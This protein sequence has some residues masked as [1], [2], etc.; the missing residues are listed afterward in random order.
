[1]AEAVRLDDSG[2]RSAADF[3]TR[4]A[5]LR[6]KLRALVQDGGETAQ[7]GGEDALAQL[8]DGIAKLAAELAHRRSEARAV[9][10]RLADFGDM[11]AALVG[12]NYAYRLAISDDGNLFD[13]VA[14][15]LNMLAE[16]LAATTVSQ[17]YIDNILQSMSESILVA[18]PSGV[19]KTVNRG[20]CQLFGAEESTLVGKTVTTLL[21]QVALAE[22]IAAGHLSIDES[23]FT[24]RRGE[25]LPLSISCAVMKNKMEELQGIVFVVRDLT[26]SRRGEDERFRL[27]QAM[28]R[29][30]IL[31]EE[32]STPIIPI[33]DEIVIVPLI[34]T[35]EAERARQMAETVLHGVVARRARFA[36]V[37]ITGVP[38]MSQAATRGILATV[39]GLR[40]LGTQVVLTGIRPEVAA[41][42]VTQGEDVGRI[43]TASSLQSGIQHALRQM[44]EK[45]AAN[46]DPLQSHSDANT[47][48]PS[49]PSMRANDKP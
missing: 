24:N 11:L 47:Q 40:L 37:D 18:D 15:G 4:I 28:Q 8:E 48:R 29:Q 31:L 26:E 2:A 43:V 32:L 42:L 19:I 1:M 17:A 33:S 7:L 38:T 46:S 9:E 3:E 6:D 22:V 44:A 23:P 45:R 12:S 20:C 39:T 25:K 41:A 14:S 16:D 13:G 34:G 30:S 35:I 21:P 27:H 49:L 10:G 36:I 5:A